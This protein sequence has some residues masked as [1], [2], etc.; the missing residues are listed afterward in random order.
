[1]ATDAHAW[2]AYVAVLRAGGVVACPTETLQGLL[3]DAFSETA[4]AKVVQLKRRGPEP[5]ALILPG[6]EALTQVAES[7]PEQAMELGRAHWPGPLTLLVRARAGLPAQLVRDGLVGVRVPGASP[8]LELVRAFA[9][10]LTATSANLSGS[11][12]ARTASEVQAY[13]PSGLD[14]AVPGD[15]PGG[16][17]ST[18]VDATGPV[19]RVI[20]VGAISIL[21]LGA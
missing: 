13:F 21:G 20:R 16:L 8:A 7:C 2:A 19:L 14:A 10:P 9:G 17:P 3:A 18:V 1:M 15:A 11:P 6:W 5:I 4:V 12:A